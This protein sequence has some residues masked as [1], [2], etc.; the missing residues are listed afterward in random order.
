MKPGMSGGRTDAGAAGGSSAKTGPA[1]KHASA[2]T[3]ARRNRMGRNVEPG[4][5]AGNAWPPCLV[6]SGADV[7]A[8]C[9]WGPR[10]FWVRD[11]LRRRV[12]DGL[13]VA[14]GVD[15]QLEDGDFRPAPV[16]DPLTV[17]QAAIHVEVPAA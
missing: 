17:G 3:V 2:Q 13:A 10:S 11:G 14:T 15:G 12:L 5:A 7:A 1:T 8:G 6:T 9:A 16:Q 4:H